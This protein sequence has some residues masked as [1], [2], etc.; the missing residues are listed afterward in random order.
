MFTAFFS[1]LLPFLTVLSN[2]CGHVDA[3]HGADM[4]IICVQALP[5]SGLL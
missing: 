4:C 2:C 3:V 1:P 5:S